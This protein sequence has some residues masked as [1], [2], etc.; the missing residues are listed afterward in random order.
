MSDRM[1]N[2]GN[3][4]YGIFFPFLAGYFTLG[5]FYPFL[6]T[7]ILKF[8][9]FQFFFLLMPAYLFAKWFISEDLS[10]IQ[11]FVLGYP[12]SVVAI[13]VLSWTGKL[14]RIKYPEI[15]MLLFC[16]LAIYKIEREGVNE[17]SSLKGRYILASIIIYCICIVFTFRMFI[18]PSSPPA[19]GQE[20]LFYQDSFS[21]LG[22][23]WSYLRGLPLIYAG[24]SGLPFGY[25]MLKNIHQAIIV[26][27]TKIDPFN[28]H[29][30]IQPLFDWFITVFIIFFG[31]VKIAKFSFSKAVIFCCGIF[32]TSAF[33][34]AGFQGGLFTN[35]LSFY[36]GFPVF[37]LFIF[38]IISYLNGQ[39]KL[40]IFYLTVLYIYFAASKAILGIIIPISLAALFAIKSFY[41]TRLSYP[42]T[43]G[44]LRQGGELHREVLL[45]L[46]LGLSALLLKFTIFQHTIH[47]FSYD[48]EVSGSLAYKLFQ[49]LD[50]LKDYINIIYPVYR[51]GSSF[52]RSLPGYILNWQV[53]LFFAIAAS[54]RVFRKNIMKNKL[55]LIFIFIYFLVSISMRSLIASTGG[56]V[57]YAWYAQAVFLILGVIATDYVFSQKKI[58]YKVLA[59]FFLILGAV[60]FF[61]GMIGYTRIGW[62]MLPSAKGRIWDQR[63]SVTFDEW[64]AM[65]WLQKN[66]DIKQVFFSDRR[67]YRHET[68]GT[69]YPRFYAYSALS[70]RQA[71]AEGECAETGAAVKAMAVERWRLINGFLFSDDPAEQQGL[72]KMIPADYFIQSR[73][74]N[75]NDYSRL[76]NLRLVFEN[77]DIS[78]YRILRSK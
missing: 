69:E 58:F 40:D 59:V 48:Y 24:F 47:G 71:F 32:F 54:C 9:I 11:C 62:G 30:L 18:L 55:Q 44:P 31:G 6:K 75:K 46:S 10:Q 43:E 38:L 26:V 41:K 4:E 76:D 7:D 77:N 5:L 36:F 20:G 19:P 74:F 68:K 52:L 16:A 1:K 65:K 13:S 60:S 78:I 33:F 35:P 45:I 2:T 53:L 37:V 61:S 25:H 42:L 67:Y 12:V 70:G 8:L 72:L 50:F 57:Y 27:F 39:R 28:L 23:I 34:T 22:F 21:N 15:T 73:R 17:K 63:A 56:D 51:F 49:R 66:S 3:R 64:Q 29:F 14:L